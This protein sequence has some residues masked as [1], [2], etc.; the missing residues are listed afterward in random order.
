[1]GTEAIAYFNA[2]RIIL[3]TLC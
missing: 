1:E 3:A 2:D